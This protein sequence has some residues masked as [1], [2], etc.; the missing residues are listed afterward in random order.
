MQVIIWVCD[1]W[2][3]D[4]S[5]VSLFKNVIVQECNCSG[6]KILSCVNVKAYDSIVRLF[7]PEMLQISS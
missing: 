5:G 7:W 4:R 6:L 1:I 3:Y 2:V